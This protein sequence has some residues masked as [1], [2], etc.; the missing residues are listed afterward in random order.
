MNDE[1]L[2]WNAFRILGC[3]PRRRSLDVDADGVFPWPKRFYK[4]DKLARKVIE[5]YW[6]KFVRDE[7]K[8]IWVMQLEG[9]TVE[10]SSQVTFEAFGMSMTTGYMDATTLLRRRIDMMHVETPEPLPQLPIPNADKEVEMFLQML[11]KIKHLQRENAY[12]YE[13]LAGK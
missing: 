13:R 5:V 1:E 8:Y 9:L 7:R 11:Q 10:V 12:L 4:W 3:S 6:D 2:L